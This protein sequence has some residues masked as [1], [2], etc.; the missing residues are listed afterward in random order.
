MILMSGGKARYASQGVARVAGYVSRTSAKWVRCHAV[1]GYREC[2]AWLAFWCTSPGW[3]STDCVLHVV[4][5]G[6]VYKIPYRRVRAWPCLVPS[7]RVSKGIL[8]TMLGVAYTLQ[9]WMS[10]ST[11]EKQLF[12]ETHISFSHLLQQY[13]IIYH[14]IQKFL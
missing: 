6:V 12:K 5:L 14:N 7:A 11:L 2:V 8:H 4:G 1:S 9:G 3:I 10:R 13:K